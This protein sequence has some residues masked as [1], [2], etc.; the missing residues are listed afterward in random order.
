MSHRIRMR[1]RPDITPANRLRL[2]TRVFNIRAILNEGE[3]NRW[4]TIL[5]EEGVAV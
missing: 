2:G 5:A 4:L 1:Y 3:R